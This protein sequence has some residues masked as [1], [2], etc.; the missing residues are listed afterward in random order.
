MATR[1]LPPSATWL[2]RFSNVVGLTATPKPDRQHLAVELGRG[3]VDRRGAR[4]TATRLA[5]VLVGAE[6]AGEARE[7]DGIA[8]AAPAL[9]VEADPVGLADLERLARDGDGLALGRAG[10]VELGDLGVVDRDG[11]LV[12]VLGAL[13]ASVVSRQG[14][15]RRPLGLVRLPAGADAVGQEPGDGAVELGG[16][17]PDAGVGQADQR[18]RLGGAADCL[19]TGRALSQ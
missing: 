18:R 14:R 16:L 11:Q 8:E 19:A 10:D 4:S 2:A 12:A 15:Q 13:G 17:G 3:R 9:H 5:A 6:V 1:A 7:R